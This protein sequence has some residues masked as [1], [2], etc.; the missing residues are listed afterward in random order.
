VGWEVSRTVLA[1]PQN[2]ISH[3]ESVKMALGMSISR[4]SQ[5][6]PNCRHPGLL[7]SVRPAES[8]RSLLDLPRDIYVDTLSHNSKSIGNCV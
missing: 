7:V 3:C 1:S 5:S 4:L 6:I 2:H 8:R